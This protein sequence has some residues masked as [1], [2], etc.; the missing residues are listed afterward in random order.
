[1]KKQNNAPVELLL[2]AL[3]LVDRTLLALTL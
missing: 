3:G 2:L 1:M